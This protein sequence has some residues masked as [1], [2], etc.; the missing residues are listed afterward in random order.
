MFYHQGKVRK[1]IVTG[2]DSGFQEKLLDDGIA[3]PCPRVEEG[4]MMR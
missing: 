3:C 4:P 1:K 2:G